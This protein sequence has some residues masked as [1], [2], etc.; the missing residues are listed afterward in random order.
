AGAQRAAHPAPHAVAEDATT[1]PDLLLECPHPAGREALPPVLGRQVDTVE[2]EFPAALPD[3]C[4]HGAG[5]RCSPVDAVLTFVVG[6][7]AGQVGA[8]PLYECV[9][10]GVFRIGRLQREAHQ[11]TFLS[12]PA[13]Y[14][15]RTAL[16][17]TLPL[18]LW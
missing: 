5:E 7:L 14:G 16:R 9:Q 12:V 11:P 6:E 10:R 15:A 3:R 2:A 18:R 8:Q 1:G 4:Q 17:S 13:Q